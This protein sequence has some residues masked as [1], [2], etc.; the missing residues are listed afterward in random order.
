[1]S[2][3]VLLLF[4]LKKRL[5]RMLTYTFDLGLALYE[6]VIE[7]QETY[8]DNQSGNKSLIGF[9]SPERCASDLAINAW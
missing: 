7:D 2:H 5:K 9:A 1:M 4:P 8:F 6:N 3:A